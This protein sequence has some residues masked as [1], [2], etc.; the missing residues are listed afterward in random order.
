MSPRSASKG[1]T[2]GPS[3]RGSGRRPILG[4]TASSHRWSLR[5]DGATAR[6]RPLGNRRVR[7][8][9]R[10]DLK[11]TVHVQENTVRTADPTMSDVCHPNREAGLISMLS[12]PRWT[13]F[14]IVVAVALLFLAAPGRSRRTFR[15]TRPR[16]SRRCSTSRSRTGTRET[17][18]PSSKAT[19]T[20]PRSSSS[21]AA[22]A[23]SASRRCGSLP[24]AVQG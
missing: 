10:P 11:N 3:A 20:R 23:T 21:P 22:T 2:A 16:R 5:Y 12:N 9:D 13:N 8:A 7:S 24:Q 19:G 6:S 14:G 17:S 4:P 18:T 1:R 15:P